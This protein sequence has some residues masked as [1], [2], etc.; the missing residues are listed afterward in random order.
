MKRRGLRYAFAA[1]ILLSAVL[2]LGMPQAKADTFYNTFISSCGSEEWFISFINSRFIENGKRFSDI[3]SADDPTLLGITELDCSAKGIKKLPEAVKYLKNLTHVDL[4][5][6]ELTDISVL[7]SCTAVTYLNV[8]GNLL[9][10]IKTSSFSKLTQLSAAH[11]LLSEMPDLSANKALKTVELSG[12]NIE[13][14]TS[15]SGLTALSYVNLS[16]NMITSADALGAFTMQ[17]YENSAQLNISYNR[18]TDAGFTAAISGLKVLDISNN[19]IT[20]KLSSIPISVVTLNISNNGL[21]TADGLSHL[22]NLAALDI[23]GNSLATTE[24]LKNCTALETLDASHNKISATDGLDY[25]KNMKSLDLSYNLLEDMP[26]HTL[27]KELEVLNIS[28][29]SIS[30]VA[31]VNR[32]TRLTHFYAAYN[33]ITDFSSVNNMS[34]LVVADFSHNNISTA[35]SELYLTTPSLEV[36][37][38]SGNSF[39]AQELA[40]VLANGY[41]EIWLCDM[42]LEGKLPDMSEYS[43]VYELYLN[44]S[45]LLSEDI[46]NVLKKTDYT[47]L[48]LGG[49]ITLD[50]LAKLQTQSEL[51]TLDIS[52]TKNASE[53]LDNISELNI[54]SLNISNC[55]LEGFASSLLNG[56]LKSIDASKNALKTVSDAV[57]RKAAVSGISIDLSDNALVGDH[58][59]YA[60]LKNFG[61]KLNGNYIDIDYGKELIIKVETKKLAKS[62][63][64]ELYPLLTLKNTYLG[65]NAMLPDSS[66]FVAEIVS[67]AA[68]CVTLDTSSLS[69]TVNEK[70]SYLDAI[71][72]RISLVYSKRTVLSTELVIY[73]DELP[74]KY[75]RIAETDVIYGINPGTSFEDIFAEFGLSDAFELKAFDAQNTLIENTDTAGTGSKLQ[76]L[77]DG[78]VVFE[79]TVLII[80][81]CSGDG[82]VNSTD[83]MMIKMHIFATSLLDG[84]YFEAADTNGNGA[85]NSTDF[86]QVKMF[87]FNMGDI[88]QLRSES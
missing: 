69:L 19:F 21:K 51:I 41:S 49:I 1:L 64:I 15:L 74:F 84:I 75:D 23:S 78:E 24:D 88:D 2:V 82:K 58:A 37:K 66:Y 72:V 9:S 17:S 77:K 7:Y 28:H 26:L 63:I 87:I 11:N 22:T 76:I 62:D 32:Y 57:L 61:F 6:N 42:E 52:G 30:S 46:D 81:D 12:N 44:G 27:M 60:Y 83:F 4:S 39:S 10:D 56:T 85:V 8:D 54:I 25:L 40:N 55:G 20:K 16:G 3:T 86:M 65:S 79:K 13:T 18:L 14:V 34:M 47:G 59:F 36:L 53:L 48:G 73:T 43:D 38:L 80:G 50:I 68:S 70:I 31:M 67:G 29:N 33:A 45:A 71:T 5:Y 35:Y